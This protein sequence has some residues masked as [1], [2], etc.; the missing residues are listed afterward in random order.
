MW[1]ELQ[2]K[3]NSPGAY[4]PKGNTPEHMRDDKVKDT[5]ESEALIKV[6]CQ[7]TVFMFHVL[8]D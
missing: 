7:S 2:L 4:D 5:R 6:R 1:K 8:L 3:E